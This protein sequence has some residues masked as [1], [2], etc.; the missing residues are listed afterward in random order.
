[1]TDAYRAIG[2]LAGPETR[3]IEAGREASRRTAAA[4]TRE[5]P[6]EIGTGPPESLPLRPLSEVRLPGQTFAEERAAVEEA[7]QLIEEAA[8]ILRRM[9]SMTGFGEWARARL[10]DA[11]QLVHQAMGGTQD[12]SVQKVRGT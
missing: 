11:M 6:E 10:S 8:R 2:I 1:M 7:A 9:A 3:A 4:P 12:A 5:E